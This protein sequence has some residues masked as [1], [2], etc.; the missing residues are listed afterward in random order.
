MI[1]ETTGLSP[2][3]NHIIEISYY[4]IDIDFNVLEQKQILVNNGEGIVD[5][6]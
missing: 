5:F 1:I 3:Y 6:L 4:I 2:K